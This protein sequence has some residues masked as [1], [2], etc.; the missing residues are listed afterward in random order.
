MKTWNSPEIKELNLSN[1]NEGKVL[2]RVP[3]YVF[4]AQNGKLYYSFS[5]YGDDTDNRKDIVDPIEP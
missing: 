3:D 1:T 2:G 4:K 5:G